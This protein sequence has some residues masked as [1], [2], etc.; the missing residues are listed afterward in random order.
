MNK[1]KREKW[2]K[3]YDDVKRITAYKDSS[4]TKKLRIR[5]LLWKCKYLYVFLYRARKELIEFGCWLFLGR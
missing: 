5:W 2:R 3:F 4:W 1:E